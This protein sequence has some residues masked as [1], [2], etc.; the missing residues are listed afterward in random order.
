ML[1]RLPLCIWSL[2]LCNYVSLMQ[3]WA[4]WSS[5]QRPNVTF[6]AITRSEGICASL[7]FCNWILA[8]SVLQRVMKPA[9]CIINTRVVSVLLLG[10]LQRHLELSASISTENITSCMRTLI[11]GFNQMMSLQRALTRRRQQQSSFKMIKAN[12]RPSLCSFIPRLKYLC[13]THTSNCFPR[14]S[15]PQFI[16]RLQQLFQLLPL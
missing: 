14:G 6:Q 9:R 7:K 1:P 3:C 10:F 2:S 13:R 5:D 11:Q 12:R 8:V 15:T 16:L 4:L